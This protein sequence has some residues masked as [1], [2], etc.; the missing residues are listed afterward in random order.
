[1]HPAF[2]GLLTIIIG[3]AVVSLLLFFQ[4]VFWT[5]CLFP[6]KGRE[7]LDGTSIRAKWFRT[8][9]CFLFPALLGAWAVFAYPVVE[10]LRHVLS[11]AICRAWLSVCRAR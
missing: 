4:P 1:M 3:V 8:V 6:A 5:R 2:Q 10:T 9:A 11:A 7:L